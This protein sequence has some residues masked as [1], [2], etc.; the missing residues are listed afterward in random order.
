MAQGYG[1]R[2]QNYE[3]YRKDHEYY[4]THKR[5]KG[6]RTPRQM[7]EEIKKQNKIGKENIEKGKTFPDSWTNKAN[8]KDSKQEAIERYKKKKALGK[9]LK[10]IDREKFND[11]VKKNIFNEETHYAGEEL[12]SDDP[13]RYGDKMRKVNDF[14]KREEEASAKRVQ[15]R[16]EYELYKR[17]KENPDSIDAMTENST[18][19]EELDKKYKNK[20][21]MEKYQK[22]MLNNDDYLQANNPNAYLMK[23]IEEHKKKKS[24][25]LGKGL[26]SL[27]KE[28]MSGKGVKDL[29]NR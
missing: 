21:D 15:E 23:T 19:W 16:Y 9:G 14:N 20:Y 28:K 10:D 4:E 25:R 29:F 27:G 13:N 2:T 22:E 26:N 3:E 7:A 1:A 12:Y 18:D 8:L 5:L 6:R 17:A 24:T 11:N